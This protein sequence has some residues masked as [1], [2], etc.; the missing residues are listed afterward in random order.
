MK[1]THKV[2]IVLE[3]C[4]ISSRGLVK[5]NFLPLWSVMWGAGKR[6]IES[7]YLRLF[8]FFIIFCSLFDFA[9]NVCFCSQFRF[10][11]QFQPLCFTLIYRNIS[12]SITT[13]FCLQYD[14]TG[15][16]LEIFSLYSIYSHSYTQRSQLQY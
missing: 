11:S 15:N 10:L 16:I 8:F 12:V 4:F 9:L 7:L 3:I 13:L 14:V 1:E 5:P 2:P 6:K